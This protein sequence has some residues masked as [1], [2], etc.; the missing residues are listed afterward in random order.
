MGVVFLTTVSVI[1]LAA[2]AVK[3][4]FDNKEKIAL[5]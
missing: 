3:W 4:A 5:S 2:L 1:L